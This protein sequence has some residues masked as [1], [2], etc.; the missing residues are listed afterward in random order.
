MHN[1]LT[2]TIGEAAAESG[3]SAKMLRHYETIGLMP[4][5][6]RSEGG[7]RLYSE[8]DIHALKFIRR[9]RD[10]GFSTTE[11]K[12]LLALW[13]N[14]TRSSRQVKKL[15]L[16]HVKVL[17]EK[18]DTLRIMASTLQNLAD[19]CHGNDRPECPILDGMEGR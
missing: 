17:E 11:I 3:V 15:A 12:T 18:A 19:N 7:Y 2:H 13:R 6:S 14:R 1:K 16:E 4:R 9:A 10:L 5:S 8:T